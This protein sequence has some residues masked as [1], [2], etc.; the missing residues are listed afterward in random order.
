MKNH[1]DHRVHREWQQSSALSV[2]SVVDY[3]KTI[4]FIVYEA[5]ASIIKQICVYLRSSAVKKFQKTKQLFF[6]NLEKSQQVADQLMQISWGHKNVGITKNLP[7]KFPFAQISDEN[8][9]QIK[10][11]GG[12][13]ERFTV[14]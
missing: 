4:P 14:N 13:D 3:P 12:I 2:S 11:R 5:D 8:Y 10:T 6:I 1:R 9:L 7:K